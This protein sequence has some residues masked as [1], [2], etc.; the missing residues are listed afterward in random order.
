M[1][2]IA[3]IDH[4]YHK[5]TKSADFFVDLLKA[6]FD[7]THFYDGVQSHDFVSDIVLAEFDIIVLWQTEYLAPFFL[8]S[9]QRVVCVPM[10]DGVS[11]VPD[12]YWH[13]M[14][15]ARI[16]SFCDAIHRRVNH[17]GL[18]SLP[19]KYMKDPA[20]YTATQDYASPRVV[21]WQRMPEHG[22]DAKL[23]RKIIGK[24]VPLHVHDAPDLVAPGKYDPPE[25]TTISH[26]ELRENMLSKA[27]NWGNVFICPRYAEGIGMAMLEALGR[28]MV[29]IAHDQPTQNEYIENGKTGFLV[30]FT[31]I[32]AGNESAAP[33]TFDIDPIFL[34][35]DEVPQ[36]DT[37]SPVRTLSEMGHAARETALAL[38][39]KWQLSETDILDFVEE[40]PRPTGIRLSPKKRAQLARETELWHHHPREV[41]RL[42]G[43]WEDNGI[44]LQDYKL[45]GKAQKK[46]IRRRQSLWF[47]GLRRAYW[48]LKAFLNRSRR[49]KH[50]VKSRL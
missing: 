42:M 33:V 45:M 34:S 6:R 10:Y 39:A 2:R 43:Y 16:I 5:I 11:Q 38:Y 28:G 31:K 22:I 8:A 40:T 35:E 44:C 23:V 9:G 17:L 36:A 25:A 48:A 7:V 29:V 4:A 14:R 21:F 18:T 13:H 30:D 41:I 27:M 15:Q 32:L 1:L 49:L 3:F 47:H 24:D 50:L 20:K 12:Y 46:R 26:F 37:R 19:V